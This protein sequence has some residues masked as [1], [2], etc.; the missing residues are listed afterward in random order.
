MGLGNNI[1]KYRKQKKMTQSE[2]ANVIDKSLR[3]IQKY[4]KDEVVPTYTVLKEISNALNITLQDL[5]S[6][7]N[8]SVLFGTNDEAIIKS[9]N[10][11]NIE[12][13][14]DIVTSLMLSGDISKSLLFDE[15][16]ELLSKK[17]K[18]YILS[19]IRLLTQKNFLILDAIN[20]PDKI[21]KRYFSKEQS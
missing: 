20:D 19:E 8:E 5:T 1:R 7:E 17:M 12:L 9:S 18:S 3:T 13:I 16:M 21:T 14:R 15:D 11:I 6:L 4:E 10:V 2:L